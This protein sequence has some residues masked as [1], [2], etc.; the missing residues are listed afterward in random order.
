M[1]ANW[2]GWHTS[3][4]DPPEKKGPLVSSLGG[5]RASHKN[6]LH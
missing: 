5:H 2:A 1:N 3:G 4:F 6:D